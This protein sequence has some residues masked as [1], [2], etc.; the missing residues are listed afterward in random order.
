VPQI[1]PLPE[2]NLKKALTRFRDEK[3][4]EFENGRIIPK[5][6]TLCQTPEKARA[7]MLATYQELLPFNQLAVA[8]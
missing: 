5:D 8:Q 3:K 2:T 6:S 7:N 1:T 4:S